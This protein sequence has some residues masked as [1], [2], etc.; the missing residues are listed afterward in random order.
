MNLEKM[1]SGELRSFL[2]SGRRT[3][4]KFWLDNLSEVCPPGSKIGPAQINYGA[5]FMTRFSLVSTASEVY[6]P[7]STSLAQVYDNFLHD[8]VSTSTPSLMEIAGCQTLFLSGFYRE[9]ATRYYILEDL[10]RI[11][12]DFFR[13][14][15]SGEKAVVLKQMAVNFGSWQ[16]R[17]HY[18]KWHL[19]Q[20]RLLIESPKRPEPLIKIAPA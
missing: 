20:K 2:A 19:Q 13:K 1:T 8:M 9:Y 18:L 14:S 15:A 7:T 11:G 17:L 3:T 10:R 16:D 5:R 6:F 12:S 4:F